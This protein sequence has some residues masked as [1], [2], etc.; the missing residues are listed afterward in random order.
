MVDKNSATS[1]RCL[2]YVADSG[3]NGPHGRPTRHGSGEQV[4]QVGV[5]G[6]VN[7]LSCSA[8]DGQARSNLFEG[9][10]MCAAGVSHLEAV[11]TWRTQ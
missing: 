8:T 9:D 3:S 7:A 1:S 11:P 5:E 6:A 10:D 4:R 2:Q